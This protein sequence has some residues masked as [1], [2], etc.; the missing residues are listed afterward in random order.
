M[1]RITTDVDEAV[2]TLLDGGLVGLPTETV[3]GLA[4]DATSVEAVRAVFRAKGRPADHPLIVH[5][6]GVGELGRW[7]SDVSDLARTVTEHHWPGPLT[8]LLRRSAAV[9]DEVTGGRDT[10][11]V[12]APAHPLAHA[13]LE[14]L[15][16]HGRAL[17]AP[18]ANRFG[19][20]SPTSAADVVDELGERVDLVLDG[21]PC[22]VGIESA[23]VDLS[24]EVPRLL[25]HGH[26]SLEE[27][28]SD[29]PDL[30]AAD[31][32]APA[33]APG[34]LASHYAPS[35]AVAVLDHGVAPSDLRDALTEHLVRGL[36]V[37]LLAPSPVD[38]LPEGVVHLDAGADADE[39]AR[40]LY[41]R[42]READEQGL[43]IVVALAPPP[44]GAG[45]AVTD[46]LRRAA[47]PRG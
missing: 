16:L 40:V 5:V 30:V 12:R 42:L 24:G 35:A 7:A 26:L 27:L 22:T 20:V 41:R 15:A 29:I 46:R 31:A 23:I 13:V 14:R 45:T 2:A 37:G 25:R 34:M 3:Y 32:A 19:R 1:T 44:Q 33:V 4:A 43:D 39:Y 36:R 21:G 28:R 6:A 17:V 10:V 47:H 9:L 11:A 38:V 8:V 18:S